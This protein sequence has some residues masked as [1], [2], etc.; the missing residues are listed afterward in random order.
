MYV[1]GVTMGTCSMRMSKMH[2]EEGVQSISNKG[3]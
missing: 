1:N 3:S 2:V